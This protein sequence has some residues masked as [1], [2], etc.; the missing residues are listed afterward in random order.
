MNARTVGLAVTAIACG[1]ALIIVAAVVS[2]QVLAPAPDGLAGEPL[3]PEEVAALRGPVAAAAD[4]TFSGPFTHD[5]LTLFL[6]HG[7]DTLPGAAPLTL[8]EALDRNLAVVHETG[9]MEL[10]VENRSDTPLFLQSGDIVKGGQQDRV[11]RYDQVVSPNSGRVRLPVFCVEQGRSGPRGAESVAA[12]GTAAEQLPG[13]RL[14][15]AAS[16][17]QSQMDVWNGVR[18]T[19]AM[20]GRT[21][22]APVQAP[23]SESS[24]QL[25]LEAAPVQGSIQAY[26]RGLS[27]APEG[28]G[29]VIGC[30]VVVNGNLHSA[31]VYASAELFRKA[32]P[33]LLRA[34]AVEALTERQPGKR[35]TAP[36]SDAVA[37]VFAAA[38]KGQGYRQGV[39]EGLELL[40]QDT[41]EAVLFDACDRGRAGLVIHRRLLT[42]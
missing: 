17:R 34:T 31:D 12:F 35:F 42:K 9:F 32:W 1:V 3:P 38:E 8:Q 26:L 30:A 39:N 15:L 20:L 4:C 10:A 16:Y 14:Q 27:A 18:Q 11:I 6:I 22:G 7:R 36:A 5:N 25:T 24:L 19:Q 13:K 40:V 29:D 33:K 23:L 2:L 41:A 37:K 21:A 28:K